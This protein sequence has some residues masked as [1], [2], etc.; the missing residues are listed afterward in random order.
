MHIAELGAGVL[1]TILKTTHVGIYTTLE[2]Q[3]I[4]Y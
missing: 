3:T 4:V 2:F 1:L